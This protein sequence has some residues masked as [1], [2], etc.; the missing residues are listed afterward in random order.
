MLYSFIINNKWFT[1]DIIVLH[2]GLSYKNSLRL[3]ALW[4]NMIVKP[5]DVDSYDTIMDAT[6]GVTVNTLKKCYYKY[7]M[8]KNQEYDSVIWADSDLLFTDSI[9]NLFNEEFDF[10]WCEDK[11]FFTKNVYYNTGFFIF[12]NNE[13]VKDN[14]FYQDLFDFTSDIKN[15]TFESEKTFKGLYADQDVL[16][17]KVKSYF[18]NIKVAP[19]LEYNFPQHVDKW[20]MINKAKIIHYCGENKP[21]SNRIT[22]KYLSHFLWYYYY[23][24]LNR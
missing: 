5:I 1:G 6:K 24:Q 12:R 18:P 8:F 22:K 7:E 3:K 20:D 4:N 11:A 21:F 10:C 16:N 9:E 15:K 13:K 2:D 19:L 23:Y 14:V 17:E